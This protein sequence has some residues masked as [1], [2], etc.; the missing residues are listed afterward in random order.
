M[1]AFKPVVTS[2]SVF[3]HFLVLQ[4]GLPLLEEC[5]PRSPS[6]HFL[7]LGGMLKDEPSEKKYALLVVVKT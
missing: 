1:E 3:Y 2:S 7:L 4:L 5:M 6:V